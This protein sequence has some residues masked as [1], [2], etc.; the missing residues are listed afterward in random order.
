VAAS[1][2]YY[3]AWGDTTFSRYR[4]VS[5]TRWDVESPDGVIRRF[6]R[7]FETGSVNERL[8][9]KPITDKFGNAI[10][11]EWKQPRAEDNPT[12]IATY[13]LCSIEYTSNLQH[14][15]LPHARVVFEYSPMILCGPVMNPS[16]TPA[17]AKLEPVG[18]ASAV[19]RGRAASA[20]DQNRNARLA[21]VV[22]LPDG[23]KNRTQVQR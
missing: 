13:D 23:S 7:L 17:G 2:S 10:V 11:Y 9:L 3:R 22:R 1:A 4:R 18:A 15:Y 16:K 14:G 21:F 5:D 19:L 6:E 20:R 12:G 8:V